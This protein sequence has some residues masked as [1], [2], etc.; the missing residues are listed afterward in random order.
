MEEKRYVSRTWNLV[1][2]TYLVNIN[3]CAKFKSN[4]L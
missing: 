1:T 3:E 2:Y 4:G